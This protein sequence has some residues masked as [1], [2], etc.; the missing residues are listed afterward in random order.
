MLD[1]VCGKGD[2]APAG[3][4]WARARTA[5]G[6]RDDHGSPRARRAAS[7]LRGAGT[8]SW[9]CDTAAVVRTRIIGTDSREHAAAP[10]REAQ[11]PRGANCVPSPRGHRRGQVIAKYVQPSK[12]RPVTP[13][14]SLPLLPRARTLGSWLRFSS[15]SL[16]SHTSFPHTQP[17]TPVRSLAN[18]PTLTH[19]HSLTPS[20]HQG[21]EASPSLHTCC[22]TGTRAASPLNSGR[23]LLWHSGPHD[24]QHTSLLVLG[25]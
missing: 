16:R 5:I 14:L 15:D 10:P 22:T 7:G 13:L 23:G 25:E 21:E 12:Y 9:S 8:A 18:S 6:P 2:S 3:A 1:Q 17:C 19:S 11:L 4:R 24:G 20:I